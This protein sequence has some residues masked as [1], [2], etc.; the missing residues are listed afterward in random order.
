MKKWIKGMDISSLLEVERCGGK[1]Y[2]H[3]AAGDALD[4][5]KSYGANL[6]RLRLWND[7]FDENGVSYGGG[8]NDPRTT[9]TDR[10]SVV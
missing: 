10:K 4:I 5:L 1:F 3:G 6:V 8:G 7:P 9:L 2:D